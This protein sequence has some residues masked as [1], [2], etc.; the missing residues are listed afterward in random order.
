MLELKEVTLRLSDSFSLNVPS[1]KVQKG[2]IAALLGPS[3]CGKST[4]LRIVA[5]LETRAGGTIWI[6]GKEV[7]P[8]SPASRKI[9]MVFQDYAL[10]PHLNVFDNI[11]Y[12]LKS[13]K[14]PKKEIQEQ[15][16][17]LLRLTHLEEARF[18]SVLTLSGGERQRVAIARALAPSPSVLLLDE[19]FSALDERMKG[20]IR[21]HLMEIKD[22]FQIPVLFVTHDQKDAISLADEIGILWNGELI[23]WNRGD[24]LYFRPRHYRAA[25]YFSD[26]VILPAEP[27]PADPRRAS[28][29]IGILSL[30]TPPHPQEIGHIH[31]LC[32]KPWELMLAPK[33]S[34]VS[35]DQNCFAVSLKAIELH[36]QFYHY[37]VTTTP[38]PQEEGLAPDQALNLTIQVIPAKHRQLREKREFWLVIHPETGRWLL[39]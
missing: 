15:V 9:G 2:S 27:F 34:A 10:F 19:P 38:P 23:E 14:R 3:G 36:G 31:W 16:G 32:F 1:L 12:G 18:R 17:R 29:P 8:L 26:N 20:D 39:E 28:T 30:A 21:E 35:S 37:I 22:A 5:G 25:S 13:Q 33:D 11:A 6:D 7:T 4:L 24:E